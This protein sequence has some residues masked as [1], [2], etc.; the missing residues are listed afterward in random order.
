MGVFLFVCVKV[1]VFVSVE[2]EL[3]Q[4]TIK[5]KITQLN[6]ITKDLNKKGLL[7]AIFYYLVLF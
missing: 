4:Q 7:K 2:F 3:L 5:T 1:I 6:I